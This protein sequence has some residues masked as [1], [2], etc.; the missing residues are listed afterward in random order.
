MF[1]H[2]DWLRKQLSI[3]IASPNISAELKDHFKV[4]NKLDLCY[5]ATKPQPQKYFDSKLFH[6]S[7]KFDLRFSIGIKGFHL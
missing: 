5:T 4:F 7:L 1:M 2:A 6:K 3:T